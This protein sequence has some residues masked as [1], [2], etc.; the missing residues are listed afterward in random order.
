MIGYMPESQ[1]TEKFTLPDKL[2]PQNIEAEMSLLGSLMLD[3]DAITKVGDFLESRD[4]YKDAHQAIYQAMQE[5]F[6]KGDPVD[7]LSVS[8]RLQEKGILETI[9]G[10]AYLTQL[11]NTVPTASHVITYARIVQRKRILRNLIS[12]SYEI[13]VMGYDEIEDPEVLLDK[14]E[15]RIFSITQN[16]LS[17]NF[18]MVKDTLEE[19]FDRIDRLSKNEKGTRGISTGFTDL[20]NMLSGF[21]KSD[22]I[23]LAARPSLGKSALAL[24]IGRRVAVRK[25][26]VGIFSLE[27]SKDQVIDR[28]LAAQAQVDLWRLRTGKLSSSGERNDFE[29]LQQ[30]LGVLSEIPL[31]IDDTASPNVL[32]MRAMARRLQATQGLGLLIVDYLQL[33]EPRSSTTNIVQQ[34]T[35]ISRSLKG[36]ARELNIPVLA[37]SQL[38]RSV[39]H[40]MPQRPRLSDLRESGCVTGD[41][42]ILNA[43][44][45][46]RIP[47]QKL[48]ERKHQVPF[49]AFGV[50]DDYTI[51]PHM[52]TRVFSSGKKQ[53]F[54]LKLRSG[55]KIKASANHPFLRID[56]WK[57]LDE[58]KAG[59]CLALPRR[60]SHASP[61]SLESDELILLAHLLGD[62]CILPRS[63]YH[64]TTADL[65]NL[66]TVRETAARL[67]GIQGR[68]VK[69][70]NWYHIYLP[71]PYRLTHGVY[72]PITRWFARL[73]IERVRSYEKRVPDAV[74]RCDQ[75][76]IALFLKHL[77]ATD[78]NI[79]WKR[80][81]HRKPAGNIYYASSSSVLAEQVQH[82]LLQLSIQ[83][84]LRT[85][86]YKKGYRPMYH[87][88]IEGATEQRKFLDIVGIT[89]SK[90]A[91]FSALREALSVIQI[92]T[93]V[94]IIPKEAWKLW[95]EP[96]KEA[97]GM[98]WRDISAGINTAYSGS[99]LFQNGIGRERMMRLS[100][101]LDN[102]SLQQLATSDVFWDRIISITKLGIEE[103]YDATVEGVHNFVANDIIIHNSLEQDAD[104]VLFIYRED[105][106]KQDSPK[107]NVAEIIIAK[108]RNGPVGGV[109]LFFDEKTVS[110]SDLAKDMQYGESENSFDEGF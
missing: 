64:Y 38:S 108:H 71:S 19:A 102:S 5:L 104:V 62:G 55:R 12:A 29:K 97:V 46:E 39:E 10:K 27:M 89:G 51:S 60:L 35:E 7:V 31:F 84:T 37:L 1:A 68:I 57:R 106:Y 81:P 3:K 75:T 110:F 67:F 101:V 86:D 24:D 33:M 94:D 9:G 72:H 52:M 82:L 99:S 74:F 49:P 79:S 95:V 8:A 96:A 48:A 90:K 59:E 78:G 42:F 47:I 85:H 105:R 65:E 45:G 98:G 103:V 76:S 40:R 6:E 80:L 4:F 70:E 61:T 109:K 32:Q 36:L 26:P 25:V 58:L 14:A 41:T 34:V 23:I 91:I 69:Q 87:V 30:A 77:W 15:A 50:N 16:S 73:G 17:Q 18:V 2:P 66:E 100:N 53:V 56:G 63:P 20:D 93:N 28:F 43:E 88:V 92:N 54:E 21:Q 83:S 44:T 11:I 107:T 13:G 22:L